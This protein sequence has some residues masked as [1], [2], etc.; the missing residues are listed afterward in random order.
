MTEQ[1]TETTN[2]TPSAPATLLPPESAP[3]EGV[4]TPVTTP[5]NADGTQETSQVGTKEETKAESK[6]PEAYDLKAPEGAGLDAEGLKAFE[7]IFKEVGLSQEQAQKLVNLYGEKQASFVEEQKGIWE[8][9]QSTWIEEFKADKVFG[10]ANTDASVQAA[11]KAWRH[12]GTAE[13]IRL[14]HQF[15]L[16]NFPPLVKILARVGKEMGEGA[17]HTGAP[18]TATDKAKRMFPNMN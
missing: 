2:A 15:G 9:Q 11:E 5:V 1:V 12:F 7:P 17:F 18:K 4:T 13:D 3:S 10:G 6:V 14:V 16:A 8:K